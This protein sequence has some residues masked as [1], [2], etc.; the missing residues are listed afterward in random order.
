MKFHFAIFGRNQRR[1]M[2]S[3]FDDYVLRNNIRPPFSGTWKAVN[4]ARNK[5][6]PHF[7]NLNQ[8]FAVDWLKVD[9]TGS[10]HKGGGEEL[11]DYYCYADEALAVADS[12]VA[13]VVDGVPEHGIG[14]LRDLYNVAGNQVVL[15]LGSGEF[16]FY[17]HLIP[18]ET[19][20]K[21]GERV[22]AG[23]PIGKVGNSGNSSE[24]HLHFQI[25]D[26]TRLIEAAA[27][28]LRFSDCWLNGKYAPCAEVDEGDTL[29][30]SP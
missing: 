22:L 26:K 4:A 12:I 16:A 17:A 1:A 18:G 5:S 8:R 19:T 9:A 2:Q 25:M 29:A 7:A 6:N 30:A 14:A 11:V 13:L 20:V 28:P 24:P 27:I 21:V 3:P 23:R 15:D 10:S